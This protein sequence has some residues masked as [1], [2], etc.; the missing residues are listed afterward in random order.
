MLVI[1]IIKNVNPA[2]VNVKNV[3]DLQLIN[4]LNVKQPLPIIWM[5]LLVLQLVPQGNIRILLILI[6][7]YVVI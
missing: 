4:A 2:I 7:L 5:V 1:R 6:T 3:R